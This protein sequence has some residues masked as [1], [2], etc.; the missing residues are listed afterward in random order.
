MEQHLGY[1]F[2]KSARLTEALIHRSYRYECS[3]VKVD[4]ER[5]EFLGD[6]VLSLLAAACIFEGNAELTEGAMTAMRTRVISGKALALCAQDVNLGAFLRMG[7]GEERS[8]GRVRPSNLANALEAVI[9]AAYLDG[10]LKAAGKIFDRV[11]RPRLV[12]A[13]GDLADDNPKGALQEYAQAQW[14]ES[15]VYKVVALAGPAHATEFTVSVALP[16]GL[17][18]TAKGRSKQAAESAAAE[19]LMRELQNASPA[20]RAPGSGP[21]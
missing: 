19:S 9:G 3:G 12:T 7:Q 16:N 20:D 13:G 4:N 14:K 6:A 10:G 18:A 1:R 8:G 2:K 21:V 15:P 11:I 5:L 17:Q